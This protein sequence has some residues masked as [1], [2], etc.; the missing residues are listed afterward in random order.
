M[1]NSSSNTATL[2]MQI[3][4]EI[5]KV[6]VPAVAGLIGAFGGAVM[7]AVL[8]FRRFRYERAFDRRA[9]WYERTLSALAANSAAL[10]RVSINLVHSG[11]PGSEHR[12]VVEFLETQPAL[13]TARKEARMYATPSAHHAFEGVARAQVNAL[14]P[15]FAPIIELRSAEFQLSSDVVKKCLA[16]NERLERILIGEFRTHV[17]LG[18]LREPSQVGGWS[19]RLLPTWGIGKGTP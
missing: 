17:G 18:R 6:V 2:I 12:L 11:G 8:A 7:A 10:T 5:A 1:Q 15:E 4:S 13:D 14:R 9:D 16:L 3:N 19:T